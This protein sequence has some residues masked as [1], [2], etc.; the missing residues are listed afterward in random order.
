MG[1][2]AR[3]AIVAA[4]CVAFALRVWRLADLPPGLHTDEGHYAKDAIAILHGARPLFLP[5]NN[6]REPLFSYVAALVFGGV[7]VSA[8]SLRLVAAWAGVLAAALAAG[9][10]LRLPVGR[11]ERTAVLAAAGVGFTFWPVLQ[12]RVGLRLILLPVWVGLLLVCWSRAVVPP[13]SDVSAA[14]PAAEVDEGALP[15]RRWL[16]QLRWPI[17][18]G[19]VLAAA[20]YTHLTG[21]LLP[22]IPLSSGMWLAW[23]T[24]SRRPLEAAVIALATAAVLGAP[25]AHYFYA[26]P[27]E[28]GART[29]EV[30]VLNPAV[31]EGDLVGTIVDNGI[32]LLVAPVWRGDR[33]RYHNAPRRPIFGDPIWAIGWLIG[34]GV[35][36]AWA[37]GRRSDR[38]SGRRND[39]RNDR[40]ERWAVLLAATLAVTVVPSWLSAAAPNFLRLTGTWPV[41]FPVAAVGIDAV[42]VWAR[43][44]TE[45]LA[46]RRAGRS[47]G[48]RS[49]GRIVEW[50]VVAFAC[51]LPLASTVRDYFGSYASD[52]RLYDI[53]NGAATEHGRQL[54]RIGAEGPTFITPL[55]AGQTAIAVLTAAAPPTEV[56]AS[57]GLLLAPIGRS[58]RYAFDP[59]EADAAA[60]FGARWPEATGGTL[61]DSRGQPSLTLFTFPAPLADAIAAALPRPPDGAVAFGDAFVLVGAAAAPLTVAAGGTVT[62]ALQ[63]DVVR[64]TAVDHNLFVHA[65][66]GRGDAVGQF[67]GPPFDGHPATDR[68]PAGGRVRLVVTLDVAADAVPGPVDLRLG[69]YD[70]RTG[71]RLRCAPCPGGESAARLGTIRVAR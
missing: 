71:T 13:P 20:F 61:R 2:P 27:L 47:A 68:W 40:R 18:T 35:L 23:R 62:V 4:L 11:P 34:L 54:A 7:G 3:L 48:W 45:R 57:H 6:G 33:N 51:G 59:L 26:H 24:R 69:W 22:L 49:S 12:S 56:D 28:A 55:L 10:A 67:D 8:L 70:W 30:S 42:A 14:R 38:R 58:A 31:N 5:A 60:T 25:L 17:A 15:A 53:F 64:P 21:R 16:H 44:R 65:V 50:A 19:V 29:A 37:I 36:A 52:P 43:Q 1:W 63:L 39:R 9:V 41:L 66:D 32:A 46:R